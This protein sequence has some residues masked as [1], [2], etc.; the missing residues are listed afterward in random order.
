[1][2]QPVDVVE[3]VFAANVLAG[4]DRLE[5]RQPLGCDGITARTPFRALY[6]RGSIKQSMLHVAQFGNWLL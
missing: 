6:V 3:D 5:V 1:M 4:I 2:Q